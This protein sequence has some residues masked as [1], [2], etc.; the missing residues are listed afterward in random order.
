MAKFKM[1]KESGISSLFTGCC[2][3]IAKLTLAKV[4]MVWH[5]QD[6]L[7]AQAF[8]KLFICNEIYTGKG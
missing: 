3:F 8:K 6:W 1:T 5:V 2:C 4:G 7:L